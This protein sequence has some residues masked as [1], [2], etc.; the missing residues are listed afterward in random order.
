MFVV[1]FLNWHESTHSVQ[2]DSHHATHFYDPFHSPLVPPVTLLREV[3]SQE[4][5]EGECVT[6][7]CELSKPGLLVEWKKGTQLLSCGEKYQMTQN[8]FRYEL[9]VLDLRPSDT[10]TYSCSWEDATSTATLQVNVRP[11]TFTKELEDQRAD[12]GQSVAL[13][14]ELSKAGAPVEWRKEELGLCPCSKYDIRQSERTATLVIHDVDKDDMGCYTCDAGFHQSTAYV[15][16]KGMLAISGLLACRKRGTHGTKWPMCSYC[17]HSE[18][19]IQ[20]WYDT[21][22]ATH[23]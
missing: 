12:E 17:S 4:S 16:V 11:V 5:F 13:Q 1:I 22:H 18:G 8:G 15:A 9:H 20:R 7:L 19:L 14:C 3:E 21:E 6:L 2:L 10:G 23:T